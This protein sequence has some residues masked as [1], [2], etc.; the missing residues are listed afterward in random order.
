[1]QDLDLIVDKG[2]E[3]GLHLN[4]HKSKIICHDD[5]S[6]RL[7]LNA[8]PGAQVIDPDNATLLLSPIGNVA[9]I[10]SILEEKIG[11]LRTMGDRLKFLISND[12]ILLRK[13]FAIPGAHEPPEGRQGASNYVQWHLT[14]SG[15]D[16][17]LI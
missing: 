15:S 14:L 13:S 17:F 5:A 11:M 8:F 9:C 7:V 4:P 2:A 1:M 3:L 6:R 12:A 10:S 16:T